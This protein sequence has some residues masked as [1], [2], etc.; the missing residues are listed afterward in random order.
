MP[1]VCVQ[2]GVDC[3]E[4]KRFKDAQGHYTC[5]KCYDR[6]KYGLP[7]EKDVLV[8][9]GPA[10]ALAD[11]IPIEGDQLPCPRCGQ[12]IP[13]GETVCRNCRYDIT[14][15][16]APSSPAM[17][18]SR[19]CGKCG[20]DMMGLALRAHCPECGADEYERERAKKEKHQN[21][22]V[23]FYQ[24][25]LIISAAGLGALILL[26]LIN[27][28]LH[29]LAIDFIAIGVSV[30]LALVAYWL[31][32]VVLGGGLDQ[33]WALAAVNF[34]AVF[35]VSWTVETLFSYLPIPIVGWVISLIVYYGMLT[36]R[37]DL[38]GWKDALALTILLRILQFG[39]LFAIAAM[40]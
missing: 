33:G 39:T 22:F 28:D 27:G 25:P 24:E 3:T 20:Y 31:F 9:Q 16:A 14:I 13:P 35:A 12:E 11:E 6:L 19:P 18:M 30:P 36:Y 29:K 4:T 7:I 40:L 26:R 37:L 23:L 21:Q 17:E 10:L 8:D 1:K 2:C 5:N 32:C 38:D 15:G 34:L